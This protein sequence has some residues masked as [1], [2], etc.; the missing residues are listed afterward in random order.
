MAK[1][2]IDSRSKLYNKYVEE[3]TLDG[4]KAIQAAV[5]SNEFENRTGNLQDS[6]A[7]AVYH[8]GYMITGTMRYYEPSIATSSK[9]YGN[10]MLSGRE[11]ARRYLLNYKPRT[12]GLSLVLI[13][14]MPYE[15]V[16]EQGYYEVD[17]KRINL[18]RKYKVITGANNFMKQLA[19]KWSG[20]FGRKAKGTRV[21]VTPIGV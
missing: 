15:K 10:R 6:Y 21:N 18:T 4:E 7:S 11:E 19:A 1:K 8:D 14:A 13:A 3:L 5:W 2:S 20:K 17:G 16:L 12:K 9:K